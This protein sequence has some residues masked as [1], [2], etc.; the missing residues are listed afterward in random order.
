[1]QNVDAGCRDGRGQID[2]QRVG[3]ELHVALRVAEGRR[4]E[5]LDEG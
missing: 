5:H 4:L 2:E 3:G 1:M